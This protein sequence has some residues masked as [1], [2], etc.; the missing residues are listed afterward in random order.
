LGMSLNHASEKDRRFLTDSCLRELC[1]NEKSTTLQD[2][3]LRVM[4]LDDQQC[5]TI[6]GALETNS[7]LTSLDIR[8]NSE[9]TAGGYK[10][11]LG[12]LERNWD[13]WCSVMVDDEAF[14]GKFNALIELNQAG[15]GDLLRTPT[16]SKMVNFLDYLKDDASALWY[17]FS[18]HDSARTLL[19]EY[20][21]WKTKL[22]RKREGQEDDSDE[23]ESEQDHKRP[24]IE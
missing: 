17:F 18:I 3:T 15:R 23:P 7:F 21:L 4:H 5:T 20:L 19:A 1:C 11:I 8:Q 9:I 14:Q 13:L 24:R 12:A 2:L 6:A 22:L 16:L 10:E